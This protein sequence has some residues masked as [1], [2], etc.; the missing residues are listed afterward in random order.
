MAA[1]SPDIAPV[2]DGLS[3]LTSAT[4]GAVKTAVVYESRQWDAD[5]EEGEVRPKSNGRIRTSRRCNLSP[6]CP[7][8]L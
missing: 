4:G 5:S 1:R 2:T 6:E 3:T 8:A 7:I